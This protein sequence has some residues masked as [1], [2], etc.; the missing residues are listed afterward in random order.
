VVEPTVSCS[1]AGLELNA[2]FT[3][4]GCTDTLAVLVSPPASVAVSRNST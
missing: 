1:P 2:R 4:L 3:V